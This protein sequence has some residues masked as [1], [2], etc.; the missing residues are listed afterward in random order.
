MTKIMAVLLASLLLI[1]CESGT[2]NEDLYQY[3]GSFVGDNGAVGNITRQLPIPDGE[4]MNGLELQTTEEPYGIILNYKEAELS[5]DM[6]TDYHEL[7]IYNASI[8][9]SLVKNAD[10]VQFNFLEKELTVTRESLEKW[11]GI[12]LREFSSQDE[13]SKFIQEYLQNEEQVKRF[14]D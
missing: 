5:E 14:F 10:W 11:Y 4:Q 6:D 7:A 9:L 12:D 2:V 8:I 1:S 3:K 13:I